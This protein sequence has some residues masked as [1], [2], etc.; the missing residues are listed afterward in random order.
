[1][2]PTNRL[3]LLT[4]FLLLSLFVGVGANAAV[5]RGRLRNRAGIGGKATTAAVYTNSHALEFDATGG[6]SE[7]V[8]LSDLA[9]GGAARVAWG[10]WVY[11]ANCTSNEEIISKFTDAPN[12]EW[13]IVLFAG[14]NTCRIQIMLSTNGTATAGGSTADDT[15]T[16][17]AWHYI[18]VDY[19]GTQATNAT[20]LIVKVDDV[21]KAITFGGTVPTTIFDTT[22]V[23]T[24]GVYGRH[25]PGDDFYIGVMDEVAIWIGAGNVPTS[26]AAYNSGHVFNLATFS[27]APAYA[28]SF[29][30]DTIPTIAATVGAVN[31]TAVNMEAGDVEAS[32]V[33]P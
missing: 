18:F 3:R 33:A 30:G 29:N 20:K 23:A 21:Q 24:L 2:K 15:F 6:T 7:R 22:T 19:D 8:D 5:R 17:N 11:Q 26:A 25:S 4:A 32:N 31:G 14:T 10:V 13:D 1:M 16:E 12:K 9:T 27:P 28:W